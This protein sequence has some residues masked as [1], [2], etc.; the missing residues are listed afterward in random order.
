V[1]SQP[2]G[3][4]IGPCPESPEHDVLGEQWQRYAGHLELCACC[5]E[6]L[7]RADELG[8][9]LKQVGREGGDPTAV[10]PD[11]AL[12]Q[13]MARLR[14]VKSPLQIGS[15]DAVDL[16]FLRSTAEPGVLGTLGNYEVQEVIGQGGMGVVLKA[17]DPALHRLVA[18]KVMAPALAGSAI[19]RLRFTRE[20]QAAAAVSHDHVVVV[21]GV[22]E[23]D[24]LPYLVMEYI[25]GESLQDRIDRVGPLELAEIVRIGLQTASG[26][27]AAHAQGLIHRDIK[28]ANLLLENGLARVTITDF[29]LARTVDDVPLTQNGAV[30]GTPEYM[31]PEQARGDAIDHR[32][33]LFSLGS[34]LY[35]MATGVP[36]FQGSTAL[37][38]LRHVSDQTPSRVR[39]LNPAISDW[40]ETLIEQ[41]MAKNPDDRFQSAAEVATLLEGYLA[42]LRQPLSTPAPRLP[43]MGG[44]EKRGSGHRWWRHA[45]WATSAAIVLLS[46]LW[47]VRWLTQVNQPV[48]PPA[49]PAARAEFYQDFRGKQTHFALRWTGTNGDEE[50]TA[51]ERGVRIKLPANRGRSDPVGLVID[52][53]LRGDF[54]A[55]ARYELLD[56]PQPRRGGVGFE[57]YVQLETPA[58]DAIVL[59]RLKRPDGSEQYLCGHYL[60]VDG[61]RRYDTK[62]AAAAAPTGQL[63]VARKGTEFTLSAAEGEG[64]AFQELVRGDWGAADVKRLRVAA[65]TA[66]HPEQADVR[67]VDLKVRADHLNPELTDNPDAAGEGPAGLGRRGWL[68]LAM[69]LGLLVCVSLVLGAGVAFFRRRRRRTTSAPA[70]ETAK[71]EPLAPTTA[72]VSFACSGCG[73][74]LKVRAELVGKKVKCPHCHNAIH[75]NLPPR[76]TMRT[77]FVAVVGGVCALSV[78]VAAA[79]AL[80]TGPAEALDPQAIG[81]DQ[82]KQP[83]A[84]A[85]Q[86]KPLEPRNGLTCLVVNKNSGR[87][88]SIT[89]GSSNPG[90]KLVQGPKPDQAGATERWTLL[91]AGNAFRLRN[92][93]S[94]LVMEIG[95]GNRNSG[96]QAIQWHDQNTLNHQHW[97]FERVDNGYVLRVGHTRM[98]LAVRE[99]SSAAGGRV[100]QWDHVPG[101]LEE[102]WELLP[103]YPNEAFWSLKGEPDVSAAMLRMGSDAENCVR[104]EP[105]GLRIVLP[106]GYPKV[107]PE[108]GLRMPLDIKG[109]FEITMNFEILAEP[110]P[111]DTGFGTRVTFGVNTPEKKAARISR[112]I[113]ANGS[114]RFAS[115]SS[116]QPNDPKDLKR[117]HYFPTDA[118][119]GRLRL[120]RAGSV[121]AYHAAK[122]ADEEFA[123]LQTYPFG[124]EDVSDVQIV[125]TT[126]GER[127]NL[128]VRVTDLR[129]RAASLSRGQGH[130]LPIAAPRADIPSEPRSRGWLAA[131]SIIALILVLLAAAGAGTWRYLHMRRL[132]SDSN[133]TSNER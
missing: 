14:E 124:T 121:I 110:K 43:V 27:A 52:A 80:Y 4:D 133:V 71:D 109:D 62:F 82:P 25:A 96:V 8:G 9:V 38:V 53:P 7:D 117:I 114:M 69:A 57:M 87:C 119:T 31:A 41:L 12:S 75:V 65:S 48:A 44:G 29:G 126:G 36:P 42:H 5:Q 81:A 50:I 115:W 95:S 112:M 104:F 70:T 63:R 100:V 123:L 72:A 54:E 111:A 45:A 3:Y 125:G 91:G 108:T 40:L 116:K 113:Y 22:H 98:A 59:H 66:H 102:R 20:A 13:F 130:E 103:P 101:M 131:A 11:P 85:V 73:K 84:F 46:T 77:W 39:S 2:H 105:A 132:R 26:L 68:M 17:F 107:R 127:A 99:G 15:L 92:E 86:P 128:D 28:P 106:D 93:S 23:T 55:T 79:V 24:G 47:V 49:G 33:D 67:L 30:T 88:L 1:S 83:H 35:A 74:N 10:P 122:D 56:A 118:M 78:L 120:S 60:T 89:D 37:A 94:R 64:G 97:T 34:V 18:I 90:A 6:R 16:Y 21:H 129:I 32:A 61:K 19:A 76:A 58:D 51:D